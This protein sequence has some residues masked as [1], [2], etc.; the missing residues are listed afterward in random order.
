MVISA[1]LEDMKKKLSRYDSK[2]S[3]EWLKCIFNPKTK[4]QANNRPCILICNSFRTYKTL[5]ILEFCSKNNIGVSIRT[6]AGQ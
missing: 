3:L 5:E 1:G 6:R 4:E 2:I